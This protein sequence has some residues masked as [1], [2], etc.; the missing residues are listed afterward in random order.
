MKNNLQDIFVP[1][2][3]A[4]GLRELGFD[5][6]C[7]G[8]YNSNKGVD[9]SKGNLWNN[10]TL[11]LINEATTSNLECLIPTW[12]QAFKFFRDKYKLDSYID[13]L[14]LTTK[15]VCYDYIIYQDDKDESDDGRRFMKYEQAR[16][17]CL[18]HL[19]K[20]VRDEK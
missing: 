9:L 15:G 18:K 6:N 10:E 3:L 11:N 20:I 17:K 4:K 7:L 13:S 8:G 5:D 12:E 16:E 1:Y 14:L 2:E 19:I